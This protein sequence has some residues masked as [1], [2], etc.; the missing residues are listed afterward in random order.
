MDAIRRTQILASSVLVLTAA[1]LVGLMGRVA[2]IQK[3]VTPD[4]VSRLEHQYTAVL[5]L[6][7]D[8]GNI[9]FWDGTPAAMSVRVYNLFADPAYIMDPE[10][11]LNPLKDEELEQARQQLAEALAPLVN[12]PAKELQFDLEKN[13]Y[14]KQETAPGVWEDTDK[15]RRFLWLARE[16]DE[17]FYNKFMALKEKLREESREVLKTE[18][19]SKD[20][21]AR[22]A[23]Q[24]KA[25]VLYHTLDGVGFVRSMRRVYPMGQL[26]GSV[27]GV[28]NQYDGIDG[29]EYQLDPL[30]K[31]IPGQMLV[32]KDAS[33]KTL[34]IQ[35]QHFT[36]ADNGRSVW[37]TLDTVIQGI[38]EEQLKQAVIEHGAASGTVVVME[39]HTGR[40]LAIANYPFFDPSKL[41]EA[42]ADEAASRLNGAVVLPYEPGSIFKPF[43]LAWAIEKKVVKPTDMFDG[44]G[45]IYHDPTG[46]VVRDTH[47][48][49]A[50]SAADVL[51]KSSNIG[52]TEIGWKMGI[53]MLH[54]AVMTFGFGQR[55]G[56]EL[57]GD[58]KGLVT[59][60]AQWNKG[61]LTSVSFGYEVAAT[62]LQL[63]RAYATF[64]NG[65]Y[66]VTPRVIAAV[67]DTPGKAVP[68]S[69]VQ[70]M[71]E[72]PRIISKQTCDTMLGI[73]GQVLGPTGTAKTAASKVYTMF[74][75]T[76]TAHSAAGSHGTTGKGYGDSIY[77]SSFLVGGPLK[78]PKLVAVVT[79]HK[80]DLAKGYYGGTV[81]A[82][83]AVAVMERSLMYMQVPGD[84]VAPPAKKPA[85]R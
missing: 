27:I 81:A 9:L 54:D 50:L 24:S 3:H 85:A 67:E 41:G 61:T 58:G 56:V 84:V 76:G 23:A 64:A 12:K 52:M 2:W 1:L 68:W 46:R 5:P 65:G 71:P 25:A 75:K 13:V 72:S 34:M 49:G 55:T 8:K 22:T 33:R 26:A 74:G 21:A 14:Y 82:P 60:L 37:L 77:D 57:P 4:L 20:L 18:G 32:T 53:P 73:M 63:V 7:A 40:I 47:G 6:S 15:P 11:K 79:L 66:L 44:H 10:K 48:Y 19:K 35:D 28:A 36:A 16:V 38:A 31:G 78:D 80:P 59:P 29:M 51:I 39:P 62:P 17:N 83:A 30:L 43:V 69:D 70:K 45:G 42:G